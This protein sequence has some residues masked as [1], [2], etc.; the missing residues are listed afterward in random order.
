MFQQ[1]GLLRSTKKFLTG[2]KLTPNDP[3]IHGA[4]GWAVSDSMGQLPIFHLLSV[5]DKF[6]LTFF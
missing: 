2:K 1:L 6:P 5:G 4:A 3:K